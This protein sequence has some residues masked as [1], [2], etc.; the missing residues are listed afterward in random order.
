VKGV[1]I[2]KPTKVNPGVKPS[3]ADQYVVARWFR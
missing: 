2:A 1:L 3:G